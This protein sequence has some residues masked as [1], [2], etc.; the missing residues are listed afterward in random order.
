MIATTISILIKQCRSSDVCNAN[1]SC[2]VSRLEIETYAMEDS[3]AKITN[4]YGN[5][6]YFSAK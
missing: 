1:Y 4:I 3:K 6:S 2:N 5:Q